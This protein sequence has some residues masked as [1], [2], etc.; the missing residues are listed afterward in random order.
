MDAYVLY[1][2]NPSLAAAIVA[3]LL[4]LGST[5][6]HAFLAFKHRMKFLVTFIVGGLFETI[7][8]GARAANAQQAPNYAIMPYSLQSVFI[9][10][11]PSLLAASIYMILGRIICLVDGD[12]RSLIRAIRLTK[13]FVLGDVLSFLIQSSGGGIL[14]TAKSADTMQLGENII[15][16]GL[17]VQILFFGF[18]VIVSIV[19][20]LRI[21]ARPTS[22]SLRTSVDWKRCLVVLYFASILIMVRCIYRVAEYVQGQKGTLQSHEYY[23]Y[24]FDALLMFLVTLVFIVFHPTQFLSKSDSKL[25]DTELMYGRLAE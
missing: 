24:I 21:S 9:L 18:F 4:F 22:S 20:H 1:N 13:I 2:Y 25:D 11:A 6:A 7:G 17:I 5:F 16:V 3:L 23:A 12:S 8:Y 15:I 10:L 14:S 19:F